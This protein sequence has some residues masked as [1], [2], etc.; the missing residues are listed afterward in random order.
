MVDLAVPR[1]IEPEVAELDDIYLYTVDDLSAAVQ[2]AGEKR[3][4]AVAQAEAIIETGVQ[5]FVHWMDQ[6]ATVPLIQALQ[7]QTDEW[8]AIE[9]ARARKALARGEDVEAVLEALSRGLTQKL[10][11]GALAELHAADAGQREHLAQTVSRL[12]LRGA[13]S[14][15]STGKSR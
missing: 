9:I 4:A 14:P 15:T 8:R 12:F 3:Q 7:A 1:D 5:S 11:H 10:L 6:R 13:S 2:T